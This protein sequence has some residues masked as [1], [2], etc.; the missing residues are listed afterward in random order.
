MNKLLLGKDFPLD[1]PNDVVNII[2][3]MSFFKGSGVQVLGSMAI[4]SQQY[5][6]DYDCYDTVKVNARTKDDA[7]IMIVKEFQEIVKNL[8]ESRDLY[9]GDIKA[10]VKLEWQVIPKSSKI[11]EGKVIGFNALKSKKILDSLYKKHII[12]EDEYL[13]SDKLLI[14]NPT[15][16]QYIEMKNKIRF[17]VVRWKPYNIL[18]GYIILRDKKKYYLKNA[19][20]DPAICKLDIVAFQNNKFTDFSIIYDFRLKNK[21]LNKFSVLVNESLK[22]DILDFHIEE[23]YFK[24]LKRMFSLA[25]NRNDIKRINVM[26]PILNGDLGRLYSVVGDIGTLLFI[27]ENEKHIPLHKIEYEIDQFKSRFAN[28]Y[29]L[30]DLLSQEPEIN[31]KLNYLSKLPKNEHTTEIL[32]MELTELETN[33]NKLLSRNTKRELF[34]VNL[35]PLPKDFLP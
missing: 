18:N 31:N 3:K 4:K 6:S 20:Q 9:I 25:K 12:T 16:A 33:L 32:T 13:E 2:R 15:P 19:I 30:S 1:Y 34:R 8:L 29:S 28:I 14:A 21:P 35:L 11:E 24:M 10:G 7:S 5:A 23:R 17:E 26:N 27:L 22:Y